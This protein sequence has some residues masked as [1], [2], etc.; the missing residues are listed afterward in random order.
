MKMRSLA[1][2]EFRI[3]I[4]SGVRKS[5]SGITRYWFRCQ[6]VEPFG[7]GVSIGKKVGAAIVR[8]RIKRRVRETVRLYIDRLE[9]GSALVFIIRPHATQLTRREL[10]QTV[11][12]LL[13]LP[14]SRL[15]LDRK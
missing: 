11:L 5:R 4:R 14:D 6:G 15:I 12:A 8:N 1:S 10:R 2:F 7:L 13:P 9:P 3:A